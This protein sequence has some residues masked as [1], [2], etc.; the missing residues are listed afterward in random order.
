MSTDTV[1]SFA[2]APRAMWILFHDGEEDAATFA[3]MP[4]WMTLEG[5][6]CRWVTLTWMNTMA[7][8]VAPIDGDTTTVMRVWDS[9]NCVPTKSDVLKEMAKSDASEEARRDI[10]RDYDR[11]LGETT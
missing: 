5:E 8:E 10:A 6:Y 2:P 11:V 1:V 3:L 7:P 4:G 9:A